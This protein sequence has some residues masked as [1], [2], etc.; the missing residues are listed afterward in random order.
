[1][2]KIHLVNG[3]VIRVPLENIPHFLKSGQLGLIASLEEDG[4]TLHLTAPL[5][6]PFQQ[7]I[8]AIENARSEAYE[9]IQA[10]ALTP[11]LNKLDRRV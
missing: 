1:M 3:Q 6:N 11:P 4:K 8:G 10:L 7:S 9:R 5:A 2:L